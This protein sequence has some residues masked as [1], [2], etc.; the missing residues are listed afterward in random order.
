[1]SGT[2][3]FKSKQQGERFI[4]QLKKKQTRAKV[5]TETGIPGYM[6]L[7][8]NLQKDMAALKKAN[9]ALTVT[10]GKLWKWKVETEMK[11]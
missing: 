2:L 8:E 5:D 6:K 11:G 4:N 7:I 9:S 1:M 3:E 10:V